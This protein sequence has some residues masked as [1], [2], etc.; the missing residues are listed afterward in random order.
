MKRYYIES[1]I[2]FDTSENKMLSLVNDDELEL[3]LVA[4][5]LFELLL[6]HQGNVVTREKIFTGIF[7]RFGANS[8]DN[9]LNQYILN[10]RKCLQSL[11]GS[12][13]IIKTVP[14]IGFIIPDQVSIKYDQEINNEA[15]E[16]QDINRR[17]GLYFVIF[18]LIA[19]LTIFLLGVFLYKHNRLNSLEWERIRFIQSTHQKEIGPCQFKTIT[20]DNKPNESYLD[21]VIE[22]IENTPFLKCN[23]I[24]SVYNIFINHIDESS[25]SYFI[26]KCHQTSFGQDNC[27]NQYIN[28]GVEIESH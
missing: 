3:S 22:Y 28:M 26:L 14:K 23:N 17:R 20:V 4:S 9:N 16:C 27:I 1:K 13:G 18:L 5:K 11:G 2:R 21:D 8:T 19:M 12:K 10:I 15:E 7:N 6:E 25:Y 24:P